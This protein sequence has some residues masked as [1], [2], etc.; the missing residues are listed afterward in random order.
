[1]KVLLDTN[2]WISGLLWGGK[3]RQVIKLVQE[4]K[5]TIYTSL[6]LLNELMETLNYKV[7]VYLSC[8][9]TIRLAK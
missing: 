4:K 5:I 3:A 6:V 8:V 1:M 2:V 9:K 7:Q